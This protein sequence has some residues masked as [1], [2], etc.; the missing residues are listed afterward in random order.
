M[1]PPFSFAHPR[2]ALEL[3]LELE[4]EVEVEL[5]LKL[6]LELATTMLAILL[7]AVLHRCCPERWAVQK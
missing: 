7:A 1:A 4:L 6:E 3:G 5:K 2:Q